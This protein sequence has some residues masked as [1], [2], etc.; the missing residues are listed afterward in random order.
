MALFGFLFLATI[1]ACIVYFT[2]QLTWSL[3]NCGAVLIAMLAL[4]AL[5][6]T[7]ARAETIEV[8]ASANG[9]TT[10]YSMIYDTDDQPVTAVTLTCPRLPI[11]VASTNPS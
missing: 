6:V 5:S 10:T 2:E 9:C 1:V 11:Q 4:G 7:S 8:V 3:R